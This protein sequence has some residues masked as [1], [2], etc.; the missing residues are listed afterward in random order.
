MPKFNMITWTTYDI[1][2]F[3]FYTKVKD[4]RSTMKN[5]RVTVEAKS[6]YFSSLKDNNPILAS[7]AFY[8]VTGEIF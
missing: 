1:Y 5:S 7:S 3:S 2:N 6:I 8:G 4:D